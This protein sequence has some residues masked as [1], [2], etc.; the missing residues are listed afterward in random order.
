MQGNVHAPRMPHP[1]PF[2]FLTNHENGWDGLDGKY[3]AHAHTMYH[4]GGRT[5]LHVHSR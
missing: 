3:R 2:S 5:I 4:L 1:P